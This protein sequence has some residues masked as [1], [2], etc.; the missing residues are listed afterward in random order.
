MYRLKVE[1]C[2]GMMLVV[3][4]VLSGCD[5]LRT[6][7]APT[8]IPDAAYTAAA[9]TIIAQLTQ[10]APPETPTPPPTLAPS[11]TNTLLP[12]DTQTTTPTNTLTPT[13]PAIPTLT[14]TPTN[15][16]EILF[17][18][19]FSYDTGWATAH[20]KSFTFRGGQG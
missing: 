14:S 1:Y 17:E 6:P 9:Q 7:P 4:V 11:L 10:I 3:A 19:D 2:L 8:P 16:P 5:L 20:R 12:T 13:E 15:I 18:D